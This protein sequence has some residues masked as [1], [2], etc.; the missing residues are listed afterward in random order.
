MV[1]F[2]LVDTYF[3]GNLGTLELAAIS[4]TF[5]VVFVISGLAMGVGIGASAVIS[6]A[7]GEGNH[8]KVRRLRSEEIS[9]SS[10]RSPLQNW[11]WSERAT[12]NA[13]KASNV[14]STPAHG[15]TF[16]RPS[17]FMKHRTR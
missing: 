11:S 10:A 9:P 2:N 4:F 8:E 1:A 6:R 17:L 16:N 5:P 15:F 12:S 3:I 13:W 14:S 7:I